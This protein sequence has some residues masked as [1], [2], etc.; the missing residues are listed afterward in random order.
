MDSQVP[1]TC[2]FIVCIWLHCFLIDPKIFFNGDRNY[3]DLA[4]PSLIT[5]SKVC[6]S[7]MMFDAAFCLMAIF[8]SKVGLGDDK[9]RSVKN[10][11]NFCH[12][13]LRRKKKKSLIS[14]YDMPIS[15]P[16]DSIFV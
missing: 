8:V 6:H 1:G 2:V 4:K 10:K 9:A 7:Y 13:H 11:I 5:S 14:V 12:E 3:L 16:T 15:L